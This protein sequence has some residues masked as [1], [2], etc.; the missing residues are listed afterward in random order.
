[1]LPSVTGESI[2]SF[3]GN[4]G[5]V[6]D[7]FGITNGSDTSVANNCKK[8][9][10]EG[11]AVC[12]VLFGLSNL[13]S[14]YALKMF[15]VKSK[16]DVSNWILMAKNICGWGNRLALYTALWTCISEKYR[17]WGIAAN[18]ET[19]RCR[20]PNV[21]SSDDCESFARLSCHCALPLGTAPLLS[22]RQLSRFFNRGRKIFDIPSNSHVVNFVSPEI[23][24]RKGW[25]LRN[26]CY[27]GRS[28][29]YLH[30]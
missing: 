9:V 6:G 18:S 25:W 15:A 23:R 28:N 24:Y 16:R 7:T 17:R 4:C 30:S 10:W 20:R 14:D 12:E 8:L 26:L 1:M 5:E 27:R 21:T 13:G 29:P 22:A 2:L 11:I 3:G 19:P